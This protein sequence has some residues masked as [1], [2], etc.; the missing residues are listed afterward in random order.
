MHKTTRCDLVRILSLCWIALRERARNRVQVPASE[1]KS[2]RSNTFFTEN[3][4]RRQSSFKSSRLVNLIGVCCCSIVWKTHKG[5]QYISI[6]NVGTSMYKTILTS[7]TLAA[8]SDD[9]HSTL[10]DSWFWSILNFR[11]IY[12]VKKKFYEPKKKWTKFEVV[13]EMATKHD[14]HTIE[15]WTY[16]CLIHNIIPSKNKTLIKICVLHVDRCVV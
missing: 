5:H 7:S 6:R 13:T 10:I 16:I 14:R 1:H 3:I 12:F 8:T 9:P 15:W 11:L 2:I 4:A